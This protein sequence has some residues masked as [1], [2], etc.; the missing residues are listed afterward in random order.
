MLMDLIFFRAGLALAAVLATVSF[1]NAACVGPQSLQAKLRAHPD[2]NTYA[3]LGTWF[4][5]RK[6]YVCASD[7]YRTALTL[8]P[9]S[10]RLFYLLGLSLYTSGNLEQAVGALQQSIDVAPEVLKPRLILAS[11]L[12]RLQRKAEANS[13]WQAALKIDPHSA[14]ALDGLG[15]ALIDERRYTE[16]I[17]LL[18]AA[19]RDEN[20]T[21]DLSQAYLQAK[22]L[23]D[24]CKLLSQALDKNPSSARLANALT[25]VYF[26]QLR[27]QDA[28]KLATK[29]ARLHPSDLESQRLYLHAVVL[30]GNSAVARPLARKLLAQAPHDFDF[31]YLNGVLEQDA[32]ELEAARDHLQQA[33]ALDPSISGTH[34]NLGTV[35]A[36]LNDASGAKDQLQKALDLGAT[37]AEVHL[38]LAQVLRTLGISKQRSRSS[39]I[40]K[41]YSSETDTL[42]PLA[43]LRRA[44]KRLP[45]EILRKRW[46]C[47]ARRSRQHPTMRNSI[48]NWRWLWIVPAI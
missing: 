27:H 34:Y 5:D 7:A 9:G 47:I 44:T 23:D 46:R 39:Y 10:S 6:Q 4:G 25:A 20:L 30:T 33:V 13:Q 43:K 29:T 15:R 17:S 8:E 31:L 41:A 40:S 45:P 38:Q 21:I 48:S 12:D 42:W 18:R 26:K 37:E 16:A 2:A 11:A 19:P 28:E 1:A 32:G 3:E 14:I 22:M 36:H 35:L 24:A